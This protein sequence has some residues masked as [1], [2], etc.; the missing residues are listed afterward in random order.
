MTPKLTSICAVLFLSA[1]GL[2]TAGEPPKAPATPASPEFAH[3]KTLVG[4]WTGKVDIGQGP[5]DMPVEFRLIAA[6]TVLEERAFAGTPNEMVTMYYDNAGKLALT[7]YCIMGNRPAMSLKSS[8]AK[9][10]T[11]DFDSACCSIDPTKEAHMHAM[12]LRFDSADT[13]TTGCKAYIEGKEV[14]DHLVTL[15]RVKTVAAK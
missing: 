13:I 3:L 7:H 11:F 6:G 5:I 1:S 2:L 8:D 4:S 9:N 10:I 15:T 12:T 14:P